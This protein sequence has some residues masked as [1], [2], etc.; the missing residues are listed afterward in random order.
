M[1]TSDTCGG[2]FRS[3]STST[4]AWRHISRC[5]APRST[6]TPWLDGARRGMM[7]L[8]AF[9]NDSGSA[10]RNLNCGSKWQQPRACVSH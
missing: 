7:A 9:R 6:S 4:L 5:T 1:M 8:H 2:R 10:C 3:A